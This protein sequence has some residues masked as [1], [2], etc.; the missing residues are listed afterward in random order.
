MLYSPL[1]LL[2]VILALLHS[3]TALPSINERQVVTTTLP[4]YSTILDKRHSKDTYTPSSDGSDT[5]DSSE[6]PVSSSPPA[7]D[8][9]EA[10]WGRSHGW[11]KRH[12]SGP[13]DQVAKKSTRSM[14]LVRALKKRQDVVKD[15]EVD[16]EHSRGFKRGTQ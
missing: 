10:D 16:V 7:V 9:T 5:S 3:A 4:A 6:V 11:K 12:S 8:G 14:Q 2:S 1:L 13:Q 15:S